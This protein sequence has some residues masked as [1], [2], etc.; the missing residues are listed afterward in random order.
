MKFILVSV[1]GTDQNPLQQIT[2]LSSFSDLISAITALHTIRD[3][4]PSQTFSLL[5]VLA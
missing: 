2:Y 1:H 5:Q 4:N 3:R